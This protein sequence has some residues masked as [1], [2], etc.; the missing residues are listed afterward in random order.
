[1]INFVDTSGILSFDITDKEKLEQ[2]AES[3]LKC[4][5]CSVNLRNATI[6]GTANTANKNARIEISCN[7]CKNVLW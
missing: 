5:F 1:M 4:P 6:R 3:L 2:I 7:K